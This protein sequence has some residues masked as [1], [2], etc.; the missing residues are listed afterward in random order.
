MGPLLDTFQDRLDKH[1]C[2]VASAPIL[3]RLLQGQ[4]QH[5][6]IDST[7]NV[8]YCGKILSGRIVGR[9]GTW[10]IVGG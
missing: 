1:A 3:Y 6:R 5:L 4:G 2:L 7:G 9:R 10:G 8:Q